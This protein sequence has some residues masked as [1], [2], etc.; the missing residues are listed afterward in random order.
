VKSALFALALGIKFLDSIPG[1][2][3]PEIRLANG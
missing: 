1:I 2:L 3:I